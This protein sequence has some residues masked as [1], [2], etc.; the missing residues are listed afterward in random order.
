MVQRLLKKTIKIEL[1]FLVVYPKEINSV[2]G[3]DIWTAMFTTALFTMAKIRKQPKR[4]SVDEWIFLNVVFVHN[5][6]LCSP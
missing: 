1:P 4:L 3:R 5:G 2:C 6:T